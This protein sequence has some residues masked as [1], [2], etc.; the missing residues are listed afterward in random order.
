MFCGFARN[1]GELVAARAVAGIGGGGMTT[2]VNIL[3]NDIVGLRERG[4]WA[5]YVNLI[6]SAGM[7]TGAPLGGLLA[8]SIGWR[9]G[10]IA[11]GPLCALAIV[12]VA[13]VLDLPKLDHS[14]WK[15]KVFKIDFLGAGVLILAVSGLLVGLDRGSN[16]SWS[17]PVAIAGLCLAP[18]FV[19]FLLVEKYVAKRPFAPGWIIFNRALFACYLCNFFAF[20]GWLA[21]LFYIP[22]HWQV[23]C[24]HSAAQAGLL[25]VP[26][27]ACGVSGSLLG[28]YYVKRTAKYYWITVMTYT[29]LVVGVSLVFLFAGIV[30][31][32]L[33]LMVVGTCIC[34]FSNGLGATTTL[35]GVRKYFLCE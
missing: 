9:W 16:V 15:E 33:T 11:Q 21:A 25:L 22:L 5:G 8:D 27:I 7:A 3:L 24:S 17:S 26:S 20:G 30:T 35:V 23:T 6:Y 10:F 4:M 18:L 12:T 19:V 2:C 32:S 31:R 13:Y 1:M 14:Y 29:G 34:A 28:G